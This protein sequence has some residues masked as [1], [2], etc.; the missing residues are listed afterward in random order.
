M[1]E[2]EG[3][4]LRLAQVAPINQGHVGWEEVFAVDLVVENEGEE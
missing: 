1:A 2:K 4:A 3:F